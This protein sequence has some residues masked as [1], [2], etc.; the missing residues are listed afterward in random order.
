MLVGAPRDNVTD[1]SAPSQVR[2]I[3]SPGVIY[4]CPVSSFTDDCES[5]DIDRESKNGFWFIFKAI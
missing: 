3:N 4:T 2:N 5:I 1:P